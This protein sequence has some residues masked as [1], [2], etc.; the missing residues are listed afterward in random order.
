MRRKLSKKQ[1]GAMGLAVMMGGQTPAMAAEISQ[2]SMTQEAA[3]QETIQELQTTETQTAQAQPEEVETIEAQTEE[4]GTVEL[5]TEEQAKTQSAEETEIETVTISETE[6]N[7]EESTE[8]A[9]VELSAS[10]METLI[11]QYTLTE[12]QTALEDGWHK[13]EDGNDTYIK[14][15]ELVKN[16][17]IEIDGKYYGFG[18]NGILYKNETFYMW[19]YS[20]NSSNTVFYRAKEDGSLYVNEWYEQ[21]GD[22]Y[23]YGENGAAYSGIHTVDGKTYCF[24]EVGNIYTER[25]VLVDGKSYYCNSEGIISPVLN[26]GWNEAEGKYFYVKAGEYLSNIAVEIDGKYYGFNG[27]GIRYTDQQFSIWSGNDQIRYNYRAKKDGS[28]YVN[29]WYED[30]SGDL[31][32]YGE[33]GNAYFGFHEIDGVRYCFNEY[34]KVAKNECVTIDGV[35]YYCDSEGQATQLSEGWNHMEESYFYVKDGTLLTSFVYKIGDS[36]YG[37]D[38]NGKMYVNTGFWSNDSETKERGYYRAKEDGSLY[39]NEWY[40]TEYGEISYYGNNGIRYVGIQSIGDKMY[41]FGYSGYLYKNE[42]FTDEDGRNYYCDENGV[43]TELNQSGW[44]NVSGNYL[45]VKDGEILQW[46][47][48]QIDGVYYGFKS[49]GV[50]YVNC[51]FYLWNSDTSSYEYYRADETGA[52]YTNAWDTED[53]ISYYYGE[54]G[55]AYVDAHEI[56]GKMYCFDSY[57]RLVKDRHFVTKDETHY[58]C[59]QD[60]VA[61]EMLNNSWTQIDGQYFYVMDGKFLESCVRKIGDDYYGFSSKGSMYTDTDFEIWG[62]DDHS[63]YRAK[64]DG[65][66]YANEWY[67]PE[68][69]Y[70]NPYYYGE[71][72]KA[73][74]GLH[75]VDGKLYYFG[76]SGQIYKNQ[77]ITIED[78]VNYYCDSD[79][80]AIPMENNSWFETNGNYL[81]VKDGVILRMR[82]EKIGDFYYGFGYDG[83]RYTDASFDFRDS[84]SQ[85]WIYYRAKSDGTLYVNEW[86]TSKYGD[87]YYYGEGGKAYSGLHEIDGIQYYFNDSGEV[88]KNRGITT[89]DGE[90]Y[91]C[92]SNGKAIKI[93]ANGWFEVDGKYL[94]IKDGKFLTNSVAEINGAYYGFDD[95]GIMYTNTTFSIWDY[96][97]NVNNYYRAKKD[98][99]LYVNE[100]FESYATK[101]YYSEGGRAYSGLKTVDGKQ[102]YFYHSGEVAKNYCASVD[103][104]NIYC[105]NYGTVYELNDDGWNKI[106]DDYLYVKEGKILKDCV[107]QINGAYYAFNSSGV[108]YHDVTFNMWS[109]DLHEENW[110]WASPSGALYTNTWSDSGYNMY[111]YGADAKR[112]KGVQTI[113]GVQYGFDSRGNLV[114][115]ETLTIDGVNYYCDEEGRTDVIPDNQWYKDKNGY[116]YYSLDGTL[117][118]NCSE[119]IGTTWY[120][121]DGQGRMQTQGLNVNADGSLRINTWVYDGNWHYYGEYGQVYGK[122]IFEIAGATYYFE[123]EKMITS[124]VISFKGTSYIADA[125]GYL[126]KIPENGWIQAGSDYYYAEDGKLVTWKVKEINGVYYAFDGSGKMVT[127]GEYLLL[128]GRCR[129]RADGSLYVSQW[130]QDLAGSWYYY[131]QNAMR[132]IDEAE[133][134]GTHY[135][136]DTTNA[137]KTNGVVQRSGKYYLADENGIWVQTPGWVQKNSCW[138]YVQQDGTLYQGILKDG[139]YTYYMSPRMVTDLELTKVDD[140]VYTID[141]NGHASVAADG[142]YNCGLSNGLYYVSD[143]KSAEKGWKQ[144]NGSWYYFGDTGINGMYWAAA[145]ST[146]SIDGKYYRFNSDG[147][148]ASAGWHIE[149]SGKWYYVDASGALATG[150]TWLNGTLYH[151]N[152]YG[153]LKTGAIV[154][155]GKCNLYSD[156]GTLL[157]SGAAQGWNYIGGAYYYLKGDSLLKGSHKLEDGKWYTFDSEGRMLVNGQSNGRWYGES[158][159]AKTGWFTVA[160]DWYYASTMN[161]RLYKGLHTINGVQYYFDNT[162]VM[163]TGEV[164][165]EHHVLTMNSSGVVTGTKEMQDGWSCYDEEGYYYQNGKPYTGWVGA[166]YIDAGKMLCNSGITWNDKTYYLGEDGTYKTNAWILNTHH[167]AKADGSEAQSEWLEIDG[168]L[169][170]FNSWGANIKYPNYYSEAKETGVYREDG[171]YISSEGYA[172][173]WAL[174]D[175]SYYYKEGE[176]F[177]VNQTKKINGDWY[178]FDAHGKM[179]TGFSTYEY[180][181]S[182]WVSY[183]YDWGKFYYGQDGRRCY[184]VGWQVIDGKWYYFDTASESATGWQIING[185]RYYFD[186]ESRAMVTGYHVINKKL[187]YFD[188]NGVCQGVSG[189]QDGWYQADGKWYYIRGGR[190]LTSERTVI[191]N[192]WYEFDENGVWVT[193]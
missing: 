122:G 106:G 21:W 47:K 43:A 110:Y 87:V 136:F 108:M 154:E 169:Y 64:S 133:I 44:T 104:K 128:S 28:L 125:N 118:R 25:C 159:A 181:S 36:Y 89:E 49:N 54:D 150:D 188:A 4:V 50:M 140:T 184:Y 17:V 135:L 155:N 11:D 134:N 143:G 129:A 70:E 1:I 124:K 164:I 152:E 176:N 84:E 120:R 114:M 102:Y 115:S 160:G 148:L 158:G 77:S 39:V 175:G 117:L 86:Y 15:G 62:Y 105:D 96:E 41:C 93:E 79:G 16:E 58:Y 112:C 146:N 189:P 18:Y 182:A 151:F 137:L 173:G 74:S 46:C 9:D 68:H 97:N 191:N 107:L 83:V 130:Y 147:T 80:T 67:I 85:R 193:E 31:Y 109:A 91:Y 53:D 123:N 55:R 33:D 23:Y 131:D 187:Y 48:A 179:V 94:Y 90:I 98:G 103:G 29:E 170:Y 190:A 99:S 30:E 73:Y 12:N 183:Y 3:T 127:D 100:W 116:W 166:Y 192:A 95:N 161:G 75:E 168:N 27:L 132:V 138:Y 20:G 6:E 186:T 81:Y 35:P 26:E 60:G 69:S 145:D 167:Y 174:I 139:G 78:G 141:R 111:Y 61:I 38:S 8:A 63:S 185:A 52:L 178:L 171:A 10:E 13:D 59:D 40:E 76:E 32:Y 121:F 142:F 22:R 65:K 88:Y 165:S 34:G 156:D 163:Q 37:F 113:D 51:R 56:N 157:E 126:T 153:E 180:D 149:S 5:Q 14:D 144:I 72:A 19:D 2:E 71:D 162:G 66:L 42:N 7:T 82:V 24:A 172:Q 119:Q 177:V 45:Y 92:D 101:Y 57:G